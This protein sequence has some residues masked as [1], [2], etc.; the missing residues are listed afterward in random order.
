MKTPPR[1]INP[2]MAEHGLKFLLR[3]D[4]HTH[5]ADWTRPGFRAIASYRVAVW[6]Q[7]LASPLARTFWSKIAWAMLR[8]VRNVYGIEL[9]PSTMIGRRFHIGHQHG[10][11][12]HEFGTI[13][14]DCLIRQGVTLGAG[15]IARSAVA[16]YVQDNAPVIG[17][18]VDFG[19][20]CMI[21]GKVKI[22]DHVNIG[23][24][25]VVVTDVPS[26]MTV[27]APMAKM[28]QHPKAASPDPENAAA[29]DASAS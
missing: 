26:H 14:D 1:K 12:V 4:F 25:A 5:Y 2:L 22:G 6:A 15:G 3:E 7:G 29:C 13:G 24:N 9:Y 17:N 20:G 21:L 8:F 10:I 16:G 11:V 28:M 23:P 18:H 27:M 19:A